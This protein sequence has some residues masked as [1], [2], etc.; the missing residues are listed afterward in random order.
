MSLICDKKKEKTDETIS[1]VEIT[2]KC[3]KGY[4]Y[5]C[6]ITLQI[7]INQKSHQLI[8]KCVI[9]LFPS[10]YFLSLCCRAI[11]LSMYMRCRLLSFFIHIYLI[12]SIDA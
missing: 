10:K 4:K 5:P 11:A 7:D 9:F 1:T 3:R 12:K 8:L 6:A 2:R